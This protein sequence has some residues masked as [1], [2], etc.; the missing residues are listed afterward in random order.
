M[1]IMFLYISLN[2]MNPTLK[3]SVLINCTVMYIF[4]VS[5]VVHLEA[6]YTS[7]NHLITDKSV[8]TSLAEQTGECLNHRPLGIAKSCLSLKLCTARMQSALQRC[9]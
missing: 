7:D 9:S 2:F 1:L 4:T 8:L 6:S 3:A 5:F